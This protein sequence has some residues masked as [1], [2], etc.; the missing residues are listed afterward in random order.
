L[1]R[2][3]SRP[4]R[5]HIVECFWP[6]VREDDVA[7]IDRRALASVAELSEQGEDVSYLGSLVMPEDEVVLCRFAGSGDAV[8]RA[9]E[10]AGIPFERIVGASSWSGR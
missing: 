10:R 9:A 8:R 4:S 7:T 1:P 5:E 3:P 6:G 2:V